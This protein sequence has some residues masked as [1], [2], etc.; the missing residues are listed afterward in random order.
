MQSETRLDKETEMANALN[1]RNVFIFILFVKSS[2]DVVAW[3]MGGSFGGLLFGLVNFILIFAYFY[4]NAKAEK[5]RLLIHLTF[6]RLFINF[7][8][9]GGTVFTILATNRLAIINLLVIVLPS[10]VAA[11][12]MRSEFNGWVGFREQF[13]NKKALFNAYVFFCIA[14][15]LL[16]AIDGNLSMPFLV[17]MLTA[18][19][20][21]PILL[22]VIVGYFVMKFNLY[23]TV[24]LLPLISVIVPYLFLGAQFSLIN[25]S[26][27]SLTYTIGS[28]V[29]VV[30]G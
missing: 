11:L 15:L 29:D 17:Y 3:L 21:F 10:V 13:S 8:L 5:L 25:T 12:C 1:I 4:F 19:H 7:V 20:F 23:K 22:L 2:I 6:Y 16:A 9:L 26:I 24:L 27:L 14:P 30:I 18:F 28:L